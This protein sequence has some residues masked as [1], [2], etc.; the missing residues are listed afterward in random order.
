MARRVPPIGIVLLVVVLV[1]GAISVLVV[2]LLQLPYGLSLAR[3]FVWL[4][5]GLIGIGMGVLGWAV[6]H[7]SFR[8]A[9]GA[10][11]YASPGESTLITTGPY[12]YTRNP[13]YLGASIALIGWTL[14]LQSVILAVATGLM[15]F[16]F[17]F[18]AKWEEREL[19]SRFGKT[20][21]SYRAS[22]PLFIPRLWRH[23]HE[24]SRFRS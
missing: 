11:I 4:G 19:L 12:A 10:E 18:V 13:L 15:V 24:Q 2:R 1:Y 7:L 5:V 8:R 20:Y 9:F 22:T 14:F 21:A 23:R 3:P 17:F 6:Q 16:H